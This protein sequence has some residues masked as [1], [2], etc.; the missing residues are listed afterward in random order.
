MPL[1]P[2]QP[3]RLYDV[4]VIGAGISGLGIALECASKGFDTLVLERAT[5]C[6]ATS[7]NS[8]RIIHGGFRY[9]QQLNIYRLIESMYDQHTVIKEAPVLVKL[10][11]SVMPLQKF[12]MKSRYPAK[13]GA[14]IYNAIAEQV[15]G[16]RSK[17]TVLEKDFAKKHIPLLQ[18]VDHDGVLL[19]YDARLRDPQKFAALI[20]HKIDREGG[21]I[22]EGVTVTRVTKQNKVFVVDCV[23]QYTGASQVC[24]R[25]VFNAA[26]P[27]V[28]SVAI[29]GIKRTAHS[30]QWSRA[31]NIVLNKKLQDRFAVGASSPGGR[32]LFAVPRGDQTSIGTGYL[33][34]VSQN[35]PA[36]ISQQEVGDFISDFNQTF[37][38][39]AITSSDIES[40]ES[41]IIPVKK[42]SNDGRKISFLGGSKLIDSGG[43]FD[44][45]STKYTTFHALGR[46]ALGKALR[47]LR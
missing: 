38:A 47:Y 5:I 35:D 14:S 44:V 34:V 16:H 32:L 33:P 24:A 11:P 18:G 22:A 23:D 41:G 39:N 6:S 12:G 27:W 8:L 25:T 2:H 4:I 29:E 3:N 28:S 13:M 20:R 10:L 36:H 26:G 19:W 31:F 43:F 1:E 15:I 45:I 30:V 9:L 7:D 37:A 40:T 46:Y 42:I 17:A 21:E